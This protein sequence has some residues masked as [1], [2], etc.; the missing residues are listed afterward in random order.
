MTYRTTC[1]VG[2]SLNRFV[3][4]ADVVDA[5]GVEALLVALAGVSQV[6]VGKTHVCGEVAVET[7]GA[8]SKLAVVSHRNGVWSARSRPTSEAKQFLE[9]AI[10]GVTLGAYASGR[11][12]D[13]LGTSTSVQAAKRG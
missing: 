1:C 5:D 2:S 4:A 13:A 10:I 12:A 11:L 8:I 9:T 7:R 3:W 6:Y